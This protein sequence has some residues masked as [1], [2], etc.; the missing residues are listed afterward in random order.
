MRNV[1]GDVN[2]FTA[3]PARAEMSASMLLSLML[4]PQ[5]HTFG[6]LPPQ[7]LTP[8]RQALSACKVHQALVMV[9]HM[10]CYASF[11][12]AQ[13]ASRWCFL[14]RGIQKWHTKLTVQTPSQAARSA[15]SPS[16]GWDVQHSA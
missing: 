15:A 10:P 6:C 13:T 14:F 4:L 9:A 2:S 16:V 11:F 8:V 12:M 1:G 7:V 5:G 3:V